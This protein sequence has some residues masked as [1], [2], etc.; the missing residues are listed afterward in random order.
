MAPIAF[1]SLSYEVFHASL[2]A[3]SSLTWSTAVSLRRLSQGVPNGIGAES[4]HRK[5]KTSHTVRGYSQHVASDRERHV[6]DRWPRASCGRRQIR[7]PQAPRLCVNF[8]RHT[9]NKS[10]FPIERA[11]LTC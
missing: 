2:F 9:E 7:E 5:F 10:S 11:F 4:C 6:K 8:R 1:P 3:A